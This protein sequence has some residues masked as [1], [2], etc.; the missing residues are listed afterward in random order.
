MTYQKFFICMHMA[1]CTYIFFDYVCLHLQSR[2]NNN[3]DSLPHEDS[4]VEDGTSVTDP[5]L[6]NDK[7][8]YASIRRAWCYLPVVYCLFARHYLLCACVRLYTKYGGEFTQM[9]Y[10]NIVGYHV[11]FLMSKYLSELRIFL[12][13]MKSCCNSWVSFYMYI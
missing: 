8:K 1:T 4:R 6:K 13:I 11:N 3:E 9:V 12:V 7:V 10:W 5:W 2:I